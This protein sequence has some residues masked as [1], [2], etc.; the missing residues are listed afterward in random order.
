VQG[1]WEYIRSWTL[2]VHIELREKKAISSNSEQEPTKVSLKDI[3]VR[4]E[5]QLEYS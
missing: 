3:L 1:S 2:D 5:W 4:E